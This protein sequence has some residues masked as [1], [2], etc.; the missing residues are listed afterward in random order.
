MG[1]TKLDIYF[2]GACHNKKGSRQQPFG[3][4]VAVY[5]DEVYSEEFS[6]SDIDGYGTSNIAEWSGCLR[7]LKIA[8]QILSLLSS[9]Q[10]EYTL[11]IFSDSELITKQF[12]GEYS[13]K[14][15]TFKEYYDR[16]KVL[17][18]EIKF[19]KITWVPREEN[20]QADILSKIALENFKKLINT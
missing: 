8:K 2:D 15:E 12:N 6:C 11:T 5:I 9:L 16:C 10:Q 1:I 19:E 18:E 3:S 4:G 14:E 17:S 20:K 13:I 7:A